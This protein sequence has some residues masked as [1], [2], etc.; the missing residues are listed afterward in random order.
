MG[1]LQETLDNKEQHTLH[2][3][4]QINAKNIEEQDKREQD[5]NKMDNN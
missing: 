1:T 2:L 3:E 4:L 5:E